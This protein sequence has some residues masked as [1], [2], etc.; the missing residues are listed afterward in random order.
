MF[1][2]LKHRK[3]E[4]DCFGTG[5][6]RNGLRDTEEYIVLGT[7]ELTDAEVAAFIA[8]ADCLRSIIPV[9]FGTEWNDLVFSGDGYVVTEVPRSSGE[10]YFDGYCGVRKTPKGYVAISASGRTSESGAVTF[11]RFEEAV[12]GYAANIVS[13]FSGRG[14]GPGSLGSVAWVWNGATGQGVFTESLNPLSDTDFR[15]CLRMI[16]G[17]ARRGKVAATLSHG[18][19]MSIPS[20]MA[21]IIACPAVSAKDATAWP[22]PVQS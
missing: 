16:R 5:M 9:A 15:Y 6:T 1:L 12:K 21:V 20:F 17:V 7:V 2:S 8:T 18:L 4:F 22:K 10:R 3:N 14:P 19:G 13:S 11:I